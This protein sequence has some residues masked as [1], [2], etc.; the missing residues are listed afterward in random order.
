MHRRLGMGSTTLSQL[1]FL[2]EGN[3]NF[4]WEKSYWDNTVVKSK[5]KQTNKQQQQQQNNTKNQ[6][7]NPKQPPKNNNNNNKQT[8]NPSKV[9]VV[10]WFLHFVFSLLL[11]AVL[12]ARCFRL[13]LGEHL[14]PD[15]KVRWRQC[16][17]GYRNHHRGD[18]PGT[19]HSPLLRHCWLR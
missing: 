16:H 9:K 1:A 12:A 15:D 18:S 4:P 5:N 11:P 13:W 6:T 8:K 7:K 17:T 19:Q 2:R 14:L 10:K 3:P